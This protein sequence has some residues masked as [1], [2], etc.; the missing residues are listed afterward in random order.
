M[1]LR[2]VEIKNNA[3]FRRLRLGNNHH[4]SLSISLVGREKKLKNGLI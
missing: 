3:R 4:H 2:M 1:E